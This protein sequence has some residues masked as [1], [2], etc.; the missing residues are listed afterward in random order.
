MAKDN[1]RYRTQK[2][3][4]ILLVVYVG[5]TLVETV[6]L[7]MAGMSW[8]EAVCNSFS[9]IAT[10]GFCTRNASI[11][12][13]GSLWIEMIVVFFMAVSGLHFGLIFATLTGKSN[14]IFR[15]EISRYYV[16]SLLFGGLI[17]SVSLWASDMYPTFASSMRYGF[18][19][20]V[21]VSSTTGF[22]TADSSVWT[23]LAIMVLTLF[24][25]QCACA[26]STAGGIKCD[27]VLLAF[28]TIR[29]MMIRRRHPQCRDSRQAQRRD[30][31]TER[32]RHGHAV[33]RVLPDAAGFGYNRCSCVRHGPRDE[34][35]HDGF[36][37]G[38]CGHRFR[39]SR[40][41]EQLS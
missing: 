36:V 38:Q 11:A 34:F 23:P 27:R 33:H 41:H 32:R 30:T 21:S 39:K 15:S 20:V 24:T 7:R 13:Y 37:H 18:F 17:V 26:G 29:A 2:I 8:F 10:G 4:Q 16:L 5:L 22:A 31:G 19:Q 6:L 9:T 25:M 40:K 35:Q 12:A 14:N 3:L 1:F 28:K